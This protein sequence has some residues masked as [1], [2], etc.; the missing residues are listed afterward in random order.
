MSL[1]FL[2]LRTV[3]TVIHS[4]DRTAVLTLLL[5]A[6]NRQKYKFQFQVNTIFLHLILC[7]IS[8]TKFWLDRKFQTSAQALFDIRLRPNFLT[9]P[10]NFPFD[11]LKF[12]K[13]NTQDRIILIFLN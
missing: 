3:Y 12:S 4:Y 6:K 11:I 10:F 13:Q 8:C 2:C 5:L 7:Q 9:F 1:P